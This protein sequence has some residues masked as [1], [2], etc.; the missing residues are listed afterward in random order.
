MARRVRLEI[1]SAP[2]VAIG[3]NLNLYHQQPKPDGVMVEIGDLGGAR[4]LVFE[5]ATPA[6]FTG[7]VLSA[8]VTLHWDDPSGQSHKTTTELALPVVD[9]SR[10]ETLPVDA[11]LSAEVVR[12]IEARSLRLASGAYDTG[13]SI[14]TQASVG[15]GL[16]ELARMGQAAPEL[17]GALHDAEARL[18]QARGRFARREVTA[19]ETKEL[20]SRAYESAVGQGPPLGREQI[21]GGAGEAED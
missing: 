16:A 6:G 7:A 13:D 8:Q 2:M 10:F 18:E 9:A 14:R 11:G 3:E 5:I 4:D 1:S 20:Y 21:A 19:S 15:A 12:L 17:D